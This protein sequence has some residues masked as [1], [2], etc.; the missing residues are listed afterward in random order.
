MPA[1]K[2]T[3]V[4][5]API[6]LIGDKLVFTSRS[7]KDILVHENSA[8]SHYKQ[9][10]ELKVSILHFFKTVYLKLRLYVQD[11]HELIINAL[12]GV[13]SGS[14]IL[15]YSGGWDRLVKQWKLEGNSLTPV[16]KVTVDIV[17]NTLA[18]GEKGEIYA[19]GSDG[20]IVRVDVQ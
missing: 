9:V 17:V 13:S 3:L 10:T 14:G 5:R 2:K 7:G 8:E 15:L 19:G 18:N 1:T 11:A 6:T 12:V 16:D 20:H 4:G